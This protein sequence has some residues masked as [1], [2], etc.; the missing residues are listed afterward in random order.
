M[1]AIAEVIRHADDHGH[2][3][4]NHHHSGTT[5]K[6]WQAGGALNHFSMQFSATDDAAHTGAIEAL[7]KATGRYQIIYSESTATRKSVDG[8]RRHAWAVATGGLMPMLLPMDI[9][10]TPVAALRQCRH[11]R[12]FFEATDFHTMAPHD[13]LK[14]AETKH[15]LADRSRSYIAYSDSLASQ[16]GVK[17]VPAGRCEVTWLDCQTG[18][19]VNEHRLLDRGGDHAFNK[20]SG[21]GPE[22]AAWIRFSDA[23]LYFPAP[24]ES[25]LNQAQRTP[26]EAG[27]KP[28]VVDRLRKRI[29]SGHW[30]LWRHGYLLHCE[31]DFHQTKDVASLRKTWHAMIVGA[32]IQQGRIPSLGQKIG[33]WLPAL[34]GNHALATWRHVMTQ[35]AGFD[36]PY[37]DYPAF[38]PGEMWTYSDWNL[39]HLCNALARVY[40][41]KDYHDR[42]DLVAR[43]AYFDA[44]GLKGWSTAIKRDIGFGAEDGV[45]FQLSLEHMGRLG[46]LALAR[47]RWGERQLIPE[48]FVRE[49]ETKQTYGMKA[50]YDGPNDGRVKSGWFHEH[51]DQFPESPYGYLTWVNTDGDFYPGAD[52]GWA[53]GAGAGGSYVLWNH[54]FGIVFAGF[55]IDTGPT[56]HGIPH[57]IEAHLADKL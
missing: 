28:E 9:A 44:I 40:G 11:L 2:L 21:L 39:V 4:G 17:E 10:N 55:G 35:S 54:R 46:L 31:G 22:C 48:W 49:L 45:R 25:L 50:N 18:R 19:T 27:L 3:I 57:V 12:T 29:P 32:A 23:K 56:A 1:Q 53:F 41:R 51:R 42:Y 5:F 38:Q 24:G 20:P 34:K 16:L 6:A 47:G 33:V 7:E 52:R 36:Y 13:E 14:H 15:V 30:A 26:Q 43:Q 37:G 8:M